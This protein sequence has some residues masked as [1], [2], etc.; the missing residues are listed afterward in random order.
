MNKQNGLPQRKSNRLKN[1]DYNSSGAYFITVCTENRRGILSKIVGVD[2]PGDPKNI[3]LFPYGMIAHKYI[4]QMNEFYE[5]VSVDQ[6]VIMP[7]HIHILLRVFENGSPRTSTPTKQT[8]TVSH[9]ISTFK[10]LCNK[11]CG[12]NIWQRS[13]HDHIIRDKKAFEKISK[14]IY[15][16]PIKWEDDCF[17]NE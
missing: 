13:F 7:N 3:E 11:E 8:S 1:Y 17:Y 5:N 15:E 10:R 6:Y 14:Y 16:N 9:F 4:K 12:R 2:V